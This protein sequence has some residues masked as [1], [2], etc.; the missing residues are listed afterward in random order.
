MVSFVT[1]A[2]FGHPGLM[3]GI[4]IRW[5]THMTCCYVTLLLGKHEQM[6][7]RPR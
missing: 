5:S 4:M 7:T 2:M 6:S 1:G 3:Q